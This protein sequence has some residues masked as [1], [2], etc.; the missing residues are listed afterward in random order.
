MICSRMKNMKK[1][2]IKIFMD[3]EID[4]NEP[5]SRKQSIEDDFMFNINI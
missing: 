1:A 5:E 3:K 2:F 4:K